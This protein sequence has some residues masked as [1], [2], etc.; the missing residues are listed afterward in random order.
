[1]T[2]ELLPSQKG[3][4]SYKELS[5]ERRD[6]RFE[7]L[8][9]RLDERH[10]RSASLYAIEQSLR[11]LPIYY[12]AARAT[13]EISVYLQHLPPDIQ[14]IIQE[15]ISQ[16]LALREEGKRYYFELE[17]EIE[18]KYEGFT[19]MITPE[20]VGET[21]FEH[22]TG[23]APK[24]VVSF[25][26]RDGC[27]VVRF[28]TQE[29]QD[30]FAK[31]HGFTETN[32]DTHLG[33]F[34]PE[35]PLEQTTGAIIHLPLIMIGIHVFPHVE[36]YTFLHEQQHFMHEIVVNLLAR[37]KSVN[38]DFGSELPEALQRRIIKDELF[39][40]AR[41]GIIGT[42]FNKDWLSR[43]QQDFALPLEET[44]SSTLPR[45]KQKR[46]LS[47]EMNRDI[48]KTANAMGTS[49]LSTLGP[50]GWAFLV[51]HLYDIPLERFPEWIALLDMYYRER[52]ARAYRYLDH[53]EKQTTEPRILQRIPHLRAQLQ[54]K[55]SPYTNILLGIGPSEN[56]M[57]A[58][59]IIEYHLR[60]L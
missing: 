5:A 9:R 11:K 3:F 10:E 17:Q 2:R 39:A 14:T 4:L 29:D 58:E 46:R 34:I 35:F 59:G 15:G 16:F 26:Y 13:Q 25:E 47:K 7:R 19:S 21:F 42:T 45:S 12:T 41:E 40:F 27:F 37:T 38:G 18:A 30:H 33:R 8:F 23:D 24:G 53:V 32:E 54:T 6:H 36:T 22:S 51:Y 44:V 28:F 57:S 56:P 1:M 31:I 52:E 55:H 48:R 60:T 49:F 20:L 43:Y 50:R